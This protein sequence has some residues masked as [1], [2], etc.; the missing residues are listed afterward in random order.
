MARWEPDASIRDNEHVGRRLFDEPM[1]AGAMD[2][3]P[4]DG[5]K[6]TNFE[7]TRD[8]DYSLD[9]LG[10]S[11][12]DRRVVGYLKPRAEA[13]AKDNYHKPKTFNGWAVL[14]ARELINAR[15]D[16]KL[17]VI[18]SPVLDAEPDDNKYHAH[19][20]RPQ[21]MQPRYMALHLRDLFGRFGKLESVSK[22]NRSW[23]DWLLA[24][25]KRSTG[26]IGTLS[27]RL[28][29]KISSLRG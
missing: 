14:R 26:K 11:S 22:Q 2:Q 6:L 13:A 5:L 23:I 24:H 8:L 3:R 28:R 4:Y 25:W 18:A 27:S 21:D 7:E 9:R 15:V 1:L 10:Q 12:V 20:R 19:V 29:S 16:P 17:P